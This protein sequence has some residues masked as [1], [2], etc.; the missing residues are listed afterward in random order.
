VTYPDA[1]AFRAGLEQRLLN[2][3]RERGIS[4]DRLRRRVV[5]ERLLARLVVAEPGRWVLKGGMAL[6]VRLGDN[7]RLTKDI[8]L[9]LREQ[10][11][12]PA[13]LHARLVEALNPNQASDFF[14][15]RPAP[16]SLLQADGAGHR[17]WRTRIEAYLALRRFGTVSID[18]SPRPHELVATETL[19][20]PNSLDFAG[21]TAGTFE[22]IDIGRHVAEKLH[23]ISR[24]FGERENS[25]VR[26]L[27]D[28][29]LIHEHTLLA[30]TD[31]GEHLNTVWR[32]R[33]NELPPRLP[34]DLP[35]SW[36]ERYATLTADLS[37][38]VPYPEALDILARL[39][40]VAR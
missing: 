31:L 1:A 16:P 5:F 11:V 39:W 40:A 21:I 6:E 12:D 2:R 27:V 3:T 32:E 17:T 35:D 29:V 24:S 36:A 26:D 37:I 25:R 18:I 9:G 13:D 30:G 7:A 20:L 10:L 34:P 14:E 8:D 22:L 38:S 33:E 4:L 19:A 23:A 28:I 15:F